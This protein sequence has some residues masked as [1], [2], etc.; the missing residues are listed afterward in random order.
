MLKDHRLLRYRYY[1]LPTE[2][3]FRCLDLAAGE[4][5]EPLQ[6]TL[7]ILPIDEQVQYEAISYKWGSR[8]FLAAIKCDGNCLPVTIN[9]A[10]MLRRLRLANT[11][12]RLWIDSIC[13]DQKNRFERASQ[14]KQMATIYRNAVRTIIWLGEEDKTTGSAFDMLHALYTMI[15]R[16]RAQHGDSTP[17]TLEDL[18][19]HGLP[20][21]DDE[22][23]KPFES[24]LQR[25]WFTRT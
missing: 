6:G 23:W 13:I 14:V 8:Q 7:V 15:S 1:D 25:P 4:G 21:A 16:F 10:D 3:S 17:L 5:S 19:S 2:D 11:S 20:N 18:R 12:R 22:R 9:V 24:L